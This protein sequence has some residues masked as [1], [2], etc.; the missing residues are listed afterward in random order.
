MW[1]DFKCVQ[2]IAGS[3]VESR[4]SEPLHN[5]VLG[6]TNDISSPS[7]GKI[8]VPLYKELNPFELC[9]IHSVQYNT[10]IC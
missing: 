7:N 8:K 4:F 9:K 2:W 5:E 10:I 3:K 1:M 6:I